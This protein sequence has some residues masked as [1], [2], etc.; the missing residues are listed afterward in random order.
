MYN[1]IYSFLALITLFS[2][3][4]FIKRVDEENNL[5]ERLNLIIIVFTFILGGLNGVFGTK[6]WLMTVFLS[7]LIVE[8]YTDY[9]TMQLYLC[10]SI[11]VGV[12]GYVY[13][14][15]SV[16]LYTGI[17]F[18]FII[19]FLIVFISKVV[20][21]INWGDVV[22]LLAISPYIT[23]V[24]GEDLIF[25][26]GFYVFTMFLGLVINVKDIF[27]KKKQYIPYAVPVC[28]GYCCLLILKMKG[29]I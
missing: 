20:K 5:P 6:A 14:F 15:I 9:H 12:V 8:A 26:I 4:F 22:L 3:I 1:I 19:F 18:N 11:A 2:L 27:L 23:F 13:L 16:P 25:L 17:I 7:F 21:A 28:I 24:F 29:V 10:F